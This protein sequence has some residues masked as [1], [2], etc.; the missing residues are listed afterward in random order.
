MEYIPVRAFD[1]YIE[2]NLLKARLQ[3]AGINCYLKDEYTLTIDPLLSPALGG[4]K[5][6]VPENQVPEAL[7]IIQEDDKAYFGYPDCPDCKNADHISPFSE[8]TGSGPLGFF[9]ALFGIK[10]DIEPESPYK[11]YRCANCGKIFEFIKNTGTP[12]T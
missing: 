5:L 8:T 12:D 4:M 1:N 3:D 6:M 11:K 2:A 7:A 10:D 9:K